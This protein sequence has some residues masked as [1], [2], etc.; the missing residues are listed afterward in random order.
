M[1]MEARMQGI[2]D[3]RVKSVESMNKRLAARW[4]PL[5][6]SFKVGIPGLRLG[7]GVFYPG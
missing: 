1:K 2:Y 3:H 6:G 4:Q 5:R 7:L